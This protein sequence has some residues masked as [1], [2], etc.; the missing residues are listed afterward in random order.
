[1]NPDQSALP[2]HKRLDSIQLDTKT[3]DDRTVSID[4]PG[5]ENKFSTTWGVLLEMRNRVRRLWQTLC[6]TNHEINSKAN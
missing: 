3:A 1:M 5:L 6:W 4:Q 2:K